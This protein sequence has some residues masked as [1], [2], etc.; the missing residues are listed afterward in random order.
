MANQKY[1]FFECNERQHHITVSSRENNLVFELW[2]DTGC[3]RTIRDQQSGSV[4]TFNTTN[5]LIFVAVADK[6]EREKTHWTV[7]FSHFKTQTTICKIFRMRF[8]LPWRIYISSD[9]QSLSFNLN[10]IFFLCVSCSRF[11][12]VCAHTLNCLIF[13]INLPFNGIRFVEICRIQNVS[14]GWMCAR[15]FA[16]VFVYI[17][18]RF[19]GHR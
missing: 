15:F 6:C 16:R 10:T 19:S 4:Y 3:L 11:G 2:A 5:I 14:V 18:Q 9:K 17:R 7:T 8:P 12:V 13:L 1:L